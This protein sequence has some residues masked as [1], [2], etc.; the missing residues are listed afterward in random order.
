[1]LKTENNFTVLE[2]VSWPCHQDQ[3]TNM[4]GNVNFQVLL[5]HL[6]KQVLIKKI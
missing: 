3:C 5:T 4:E 1:M 2:Q 6:Y